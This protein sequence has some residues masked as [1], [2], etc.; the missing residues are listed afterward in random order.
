LTQEKKRKD[1][2]NRRTALRTRD[3][4]RGVMLPRG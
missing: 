1:K 4:R 3:L 2:A